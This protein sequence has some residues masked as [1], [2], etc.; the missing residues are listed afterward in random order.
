MPIR[1]DAIDV[2]LLALLQSHGALTATELAGKVGLSQ[3]PVWR[4]I[5]RLEQEQV[6]RGRYALLDKRRLGFDVTVLVQ[7]KFG[8]R[9]PNA[10][11]RFEAAIRGMPEVQECHMLMGNMD[12]MLKVVTRNVEAYERFLRTKLSTL[13]GV[14][15]IQSSLSLMEV[16]CSLELP[17]EQLKAATP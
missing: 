9:S 16:K 13:R 4:R 17:L 1:L 8:R 10:V 11:A 5:H 2:E 3:S 14:K 12:F 7:V 15:E 6:L